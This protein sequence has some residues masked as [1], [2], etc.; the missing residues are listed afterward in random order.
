M[1]YLVPALNPER[2][3]IEKFAVAELPPEALEPLPF[4]WQTWGS[5]QA[6]STPRS[7]VEVRFGGRTA[8]LIGLGR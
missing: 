1:T 7:G 2:K 6:R 5:G 4:N 8:V 3:V